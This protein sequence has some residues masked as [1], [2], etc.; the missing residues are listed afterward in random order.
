M[1]RLSNCLHS[2]VTFPVCRSF[3]EKLFR[4]RSFSRWYMNSICSCNWGSFHQAFCS[5]LIALQL[6]YTQYFL[7]QLSSYS[8]LLDS[9]CCIKGIPSSVVSSSIGVLSFPSLPNRDNEASAWFL[10]PALR[11]SSK[12]NST[13]Q[14]LE[15]GRCHVESAR[16]RIHLKASW[17]WISSLLD[18]ILGERWPRLRKGIHDASC[19]SSSL[20]C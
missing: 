18:T 19:R 5:S 14:R 10:I 11:T 16:F 13:K 4:T 8:S 9:M 1:R 15:L 20:W 3:F 6:S 7:A 17:L 12:S 2:C